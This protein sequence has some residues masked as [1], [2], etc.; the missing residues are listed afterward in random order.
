MVITIDQYTIGENKTINAVNYCLDKFDTAFG[1]KE[2][3][4][5]PLVLDLKFKEHELK[6]KDY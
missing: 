2:S 6:G 3:K 1:I 4:T 5:I